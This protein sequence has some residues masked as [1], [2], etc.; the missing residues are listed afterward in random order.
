MTLSSVSEGDGVVKLALQLCPC[1]QVGGDTVH[2]GRRGSS[3][4]KEDELVLNLLSLRCLEMELSGESCKG[5]LELES[6][7]CAGKGPAAN[8][9]N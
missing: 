7:V 8:V 5:D 3:L 9:G 6:E 1:G 2:R 4:G